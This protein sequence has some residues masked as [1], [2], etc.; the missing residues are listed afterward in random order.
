MRG[1]CSTT[2]ELFDPAADIFAT[3]A[4]MASPR[5]GHAATRLPDGRVLVTGGRNALPGTVLN[6]A[7]FYNGPF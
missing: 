7:E 5:S 2:S 4:T 3:G 1:Q 6:S